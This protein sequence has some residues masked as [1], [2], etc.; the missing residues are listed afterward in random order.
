MKIAYVAIGGEGSR[1]GIMKKV[2]QTI[3]IWRQLGHDVTLVMGCRKFSPK[4][5]DFESGNFKH[6]DP[7][8]FAWKSKAHRVAVE[9]QIIQCLRKLELDFIYLRNLVP[10]PALL[11]LSSVAPVI[12]EINTEEFY[13]YPRTF[14]LRGFYYRLI[15]RWM[16]SR[17]FG[18][19]A[20]SREIADSPNYRKYQKPTLVIGNGAIIAEDKILPPSGNIH[21]RFVCM[22]DTDWPWVGIDKLKFLA[23]AIPDSKID[24]V[25]PL[26][27]QRYGLD[28]IPNVIIHGKIS[29]PDILKR[30]LMQ[31]DI[32]ISTL[33]LHR[34]NMNEAS[35]LKSRDYLS[36]GLPIIAGYKDTDFPYGA[37]FILQLPNTED[38]VMA[39]IGTV[40]EFAYKWVNRRLTLEDIK[41]ICQIEKEKT[42]LQFVGHLL[43]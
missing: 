11:A 24:I 33:A 7:I 3:S 21:P 17:A 5:L 2:L 41:P 9:F 22:F 10:T 13:E 29:D 8:I 12:L 14:P 6:V 36:H 37:P 18:F 26:D 43:Q 34:K 15:A 32:G 20:V 40:R 39:N 1:S 38:N 4:W 16:L 31:A 19:I 25:G 27:P 23:L 28:G 35:P 42:R 30:V